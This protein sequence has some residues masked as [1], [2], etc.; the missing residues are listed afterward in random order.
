VSPWN[1]LWARHVWLRQEGDQ[2]S[3]P[4]CREVP[5]FCDQFWL[6]NILLIKKGDLPSHIKGQ[7]KCSIIPILSHSNQHQH[8][9]VVRLEHLILDRLATKQRNL[10]QF[11][12]FDMSENFPLQN[13]HQAI[14]NHLIWWYWPETK[15]HK[16]GAKI[17][18]HYLKN[19]TEVLKLFKVYCKSLNWPLNK[20]KLD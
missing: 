10:P 9:T 12:K 17:R 5:Y 6:K 11:W 19:K 1:S 2:I 13:I 7:C 3:P 20:S 16:K 14:L 18:F 4:G 8:V 15:V